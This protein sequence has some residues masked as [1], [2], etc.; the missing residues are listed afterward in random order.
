MAKGP[1]D[2]NK[3][4]HKSYKGKNVFDEMCMRNKDKTSNHTLRRIIAMIH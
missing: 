3:W 2:N 1:N 4:T